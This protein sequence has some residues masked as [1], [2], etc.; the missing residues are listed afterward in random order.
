MLCVG[1]AITVHCD[2]CCAESDVAVVGSGNPSEEED[3]KAE[4]GVSS[5]VRM[6]WVCPVG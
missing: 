6:R 2:W 4:V 1:N 3:G 5:G